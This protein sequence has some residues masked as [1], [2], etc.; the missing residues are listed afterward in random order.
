VLIM[1][2]GIGAEIHV[3]MAGGAR[4]PTIEGEIAVVAA[5]ARCLAA[6]AIPMGRVIE[7]HRPTRSVAIDEQG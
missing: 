5:G 1:I 2:E 6:E 4:G 3:R 7:K